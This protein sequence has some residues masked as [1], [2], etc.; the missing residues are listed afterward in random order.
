MLDGCVCMCVFRRFICL[1]YG[2]VCVRVQIR[3][4]VC[5][6][7]VCVYVCVCVFRM[8]VN[9]HV[10]VRYFPALILVCTNILLSNNNKANLLLSNK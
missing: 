5:V 7:D 1:M 3:S 2:Y 8:N 9:V 6:L 4:R 10:C